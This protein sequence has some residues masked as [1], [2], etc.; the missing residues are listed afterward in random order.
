[1]SNEQQ[2]RLRR[3]MPGE[4]VFEGSEQ[5]T[6]EILPSVE[7]LTP[8]EREQGVIARVGRD[9]VERRLREGEPPEPRG[10][11]S[12][13]RPDEDELMAITYRIAGYFTLV[14]VLI[15]VVIATGWVVTLTVGV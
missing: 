4:T 1:M 11:T 2:Y 12:A 14:I 3:R 8:E 6:V 10:T 13:G 9:R 5:E 15:L 7:E